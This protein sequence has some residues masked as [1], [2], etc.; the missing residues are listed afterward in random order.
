[1]HKSV[2]VLR[3]CFSRSD[4]AIKSTASPHRS[5]HI[6]L[7]NAAPISKSASV[8][9]YR[10]L[11]RSNHHK[12]RNGP[13]L[14]NARKRHSSGRSTSVRRISLARL[15][16]CNRDKRNSTA[17]RRCRT[18]GRGTHRKVGISSALSKART[19]HSLDKSELVRRA[20]L[21]RSD[22]AIEITATPHSREISNAW[23]GKW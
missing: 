23:M 14:S 12:V 7:S 8:R 15:G 21:S 5:G 19:R 11:G 13:A 17:F 9:R 22:A 1:M 18:M 16:R 6:E 10:M 4:A 2:P 3:T 20:Y